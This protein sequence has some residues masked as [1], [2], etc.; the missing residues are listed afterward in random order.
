[1]KTSLFK[2]ASCV[3][4]YRISQYLFLI[5]TNQLSKAYNLSQLLPSAVWRKALGKSV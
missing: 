1:M 3:V 4:K 5:L 2:I